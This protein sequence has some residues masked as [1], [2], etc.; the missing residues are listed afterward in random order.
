MSD[1]GEID[2]GFNRPSF[3]TVY[4]VGAVCFPPTAL[5]PLSTST[6]RAIALLLTQHVSLVQNVAFEL[7][8]AAQHEQLESAFK[9]RRGGWHPK[10]RL[11]V[12]YGRDDEGAHAWEHDTSRS[13]MWFY[14]QAPDEPYYNQLFCN[15][16]G[17]PRRLFQLSQQNE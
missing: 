2:R 16:V 11:H 12:L 10:P 15:V 7:L 14:I 6:K 3:C 5:M 1:N 17:V 9:R 4:L 13:T 8:G